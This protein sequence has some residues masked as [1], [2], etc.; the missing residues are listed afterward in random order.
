MPQDPAH[1]SNILMELLKA[2]KMHNFYP[3]GHPNLD[4]ALEKCYSLI[5]KTVVEEG[6]LKWKVD[7]KGFYSGTTLLAAGN[8]DVLTLAKKMFFKRINELTFTQRVA[9]GD[10]KIL[11][12]VLKLEA[13]DLTQ[14]GGAE[15]VFATGGVQGILINS[16]SY[17]D[18][19]KLKNELEEKREKEELAREEAEKKEEE[20]G[21]TTEEEQK[22]PPPPEAP[23]PEDVNLPTLIER[24]RE[25]QDAIRYR[26]LCARIKEKCSQLLAVKKFDDVSFALFV[27][28]VHAG[29]AW[30]KP[31]EIRQMAAQTLKECLNDDILRYLIGRIGAKEEPMRQDIQRILLHGGTAAVELLLDAV[32][33]SPEAV[34]RRNYYNTIILYGP[35]IRPN[36]EARL[37][38]AQWFVIRQMVSILGDLGD[39]AAIEALEGAYKHTDTRVKKEV[40]KSLVKLP[41]PRSIAAL[42]K[43]LDETEESLVSQAVISLGMLK[44][45]SS[46]D[47]LAK[48]A[49]KR[50]AFSEPKDYIKEAIK[51]LGNIGD[52]RCV[53]HLRDILLRTVWLGRRA[54]EESRV[55]AANSLGQIC[56]AEA[57]AAIEQAIKGSTGELYNACKRILDGRDKSKITPDGRAV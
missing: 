55:L 52:A 25:E 12:T 2:V 33:S 4:L 23:K 3:D 27:F 8:T 7:Q 26:D 24:I 11:L 35:S 19:G 28:G 9:L 54:N 37:P 34:A 56:N 14:K 21:E 31:D 5:Q 29:E 13:D 10:M 6:E 16:L 20:E 40:L 50:D 57:Y 46:I 49:Q 22:E 43:G 51:A 18:L 48:L 39:T 53:P 44:D 45:T 36:V 17:E 1:Y 42:I 15:G 47:L 32:I 41:S 38:G 30:H